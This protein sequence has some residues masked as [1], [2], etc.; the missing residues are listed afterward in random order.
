MILKDKPCI[1]LV[2]YYPGP[3]TSVLQVF[4]NGRWIYYWCRQQKMMF[5]S[6][7]EERGE[8]GMVTSLIPIPQWRFRRPSVGEDWLRKSVKANLQFVKRS[9]DPV[10]SWTKLPQS[11]DHQYLCSIKHPARFQNANQVIIT[12]RAVLVFF[13]WLK[14]MNE[15]T[16]PF[17][18]FFVSSYC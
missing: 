13:L 7:R 8:G 14:N 18:L 6:L 11:Q 5:A 3:S 17:L 2:N 1:Y 4:G 9:H 10:I 16:T 12:A 15:I